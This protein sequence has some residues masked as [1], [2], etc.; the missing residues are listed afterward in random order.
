MK[1]RKI[2]TVDAVQWFKP[3]DHHNV[4]KLDFPF[5]SSMYTI[6]IKGDC[7]ASIYAGDWIVTHADGTHSVCTAAEFVR[8]YE[9]AESIRPTREQIIQLIDHDPEAVIQSAD[10]ILALFEPMS[11]R[12]HE[13]EL[14]VAQL[15]EQIDAIYDDE[16]GESL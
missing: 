1:F 9:D 5:V 16:A 7:I 11:N 15:N 2:E 8:E 10:A 13:L 6:K 14:E 3:G 4:K 12:I